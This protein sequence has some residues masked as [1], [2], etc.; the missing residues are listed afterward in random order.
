M[1]ALIPVTSSQLAAVGY[2]EETCELVIEFSGSGRTRNAIYS[3]QGVPPELARGLLAA[4][5]P[6]AFFHQ[7]I[8]QGPF[9]YRRH[10]SG[11]LQD[12][13]PHSGQSAS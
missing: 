7:H 2:D 8:R 10:E 1:I 12:E 6:G 4:A 3:H 9:R 11:A 13:E 5:S